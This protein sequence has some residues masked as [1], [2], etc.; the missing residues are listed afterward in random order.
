MQKRLTIAN[1]MEITRYRL[2]SDIWSLRR[3]PATYARYG[4]H[5]LLKR[6]MP[7]KLVM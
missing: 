7:R 6:N 2:I 4:N 1:S 3:T 5:N